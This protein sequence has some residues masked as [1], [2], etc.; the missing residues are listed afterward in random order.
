M[1]F[2]E[3]IYTRFSMNGIFEVKIGD[4]YAIFVEFYRFLSIFA[5]KKQFYAQKGINLL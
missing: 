5:S 3:G 2:G 4:L 1:T